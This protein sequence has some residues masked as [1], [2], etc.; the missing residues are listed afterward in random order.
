M[1]D[2]KFKGQEIWNAGVGVFLNSS[3][4]NAGE[5]ISVMVKATKNIVLVL[6]SYHKNGEIREVQLNSIVSDVCK[7]NSTNV[8]NISLPDLSDRA[9]SIRM[10]RYSGHPVMRVSGSSD[11]N[12]SML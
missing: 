10:V 2:F 5:I 6:S 4:V 12:I 1:S 3:D 7:R 11:K 8:Y 9:L